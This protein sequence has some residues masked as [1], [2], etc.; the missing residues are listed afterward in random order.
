LDSIGNS[1][2]F[3]ENFESVLSNQDERI[4]TEAIEQL[5]LLSNAVLSEAAESIAAQGKTVSRSTS[6]Q[7]KEG[8]VRHVRY[9]LELRLDDKVSKAQD[10]LDVLARECKSLAI[11]AIASIKEG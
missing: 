9:P 4:P 8:N 6:K 2:N 1:L 10:V 7:H 5:R 11:K 3:L